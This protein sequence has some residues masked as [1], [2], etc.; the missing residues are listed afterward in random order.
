MWLSRA[1]VQ[2]EP[3]TVPRHALA[4]SPLPQARPSSR[5]ARVAAPPWG[6]VLGLAWVVLALGAYL[7]PALWD[8]F[9]FGP[10]DIANQLSFLT[11]IPH[12]AVHNGLNGDIITQAVPWNALDWVAVHHGQL[13]LWDTYS[14][15][16]MPLFLNFESSPFALPTLI[17]Y[18]FP[19]A[20]S[21]LAGIAIS[22]L[23][24]GTGTYTAARLAGAGPL[25]AALAGTTFMLSGS[26]SG[27]AGWAVSG[28]LTWAGWLVAGALLCCQPGR[29]RWAGVV[30]ISLSSGFAVYEG[31]PESLLF[32]GIAVGT[33][34]LVCGALAVARGKLDLMGPLCLLG[35]VAGGVALSAPLWLPGLAVL[36]QS[37]RAAENGTGGLPAHALALLLAQGYDG[38]PT[39]GSSWF[40]PADYYE[41]TGYIGVVAVVLALVAVLVAWRRPIVAALTATVLVSLGVIYVPATQRL[42]TR[43]GAGSIA[44]Q[45][46]LPM[47]AFAVAMLAGL[48][49]DT[50]QRRWREPVVQLKALASVVACGAVLAFLLASASA[51]GLSPAELSV[52]RHSLFWPALSLLAMGLLA[53]GLLAMGR[54][55]MGRLATAGLPVLAPRASMRQRERTLKPTGATLWTASVACLLLLAAQ[56]AYLVWAGVGV[57][58]FAARP[59]PVTPAVARLQHLV[60]H[61]LLAL[62][63]TNKHDVTLW[64]GVGIYPEVNIGYGLRELAV[65][66][67][68]IPPAYYRTWPS[69]AATLNAGLGNNFFAPAVGSATRARY[70]G[71]AFILASPGSVPRGTEFVT[72]FSVPLA[73]SLSLYRVPGARQF[74]FG[75][76]TDA[77][78][79][80]STQTGNSSWR[81][82]VHVPTASALTL[83][84]TYFP[85]WHVTADGRA[86]PVSETGGL[87]VGSTIPAGTRTITVNYWPEGLTAGFALALT[88][89]AL[90]VIGSALVLAWPGRSRSIFSLTTSEEPPGGMLTP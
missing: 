73:G 65:H 79:I 34:V 2:A 43:L 9:S 16:G 46:M 8:G 54:L 39:K 55:A 67:P 50:L 12:L 69:Q 32:I 37:S 80:S 38:L 51:K 47:L 89:I 42:F 11:Y 24:A 87:F 66:D 59:F 83:R 22:L 84:L 31:M 68:V 63:G 28:P 29:R 76:G 77:R 3:Q 19:L 4:S 49:T 35:G 27:W 58:S 86:L 26:L 70:Y 40:G 71:A 45:R 90:L 74:T 33:I 41:A 17:G 13:P 53:M 62:D 5:L 30:V 44:T 36:R 7:S 64:S 10:T 88:A 48:G 18:A 20:S 72:K 75:G 85:G 60:G 15:A 52:R 81:L 1:Q 56:S 23:V 61:N 57:N 14:G 82:Q 6:D 78:V 25:G 21:F